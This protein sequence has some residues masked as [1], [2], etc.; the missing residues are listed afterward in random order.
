MKRPHHGGIF[1]MTGEG[2]F[3]SPVLAEAFWARRAHE[4]RVHDPQH[5]VAPESGIGLEAIFTA[6]AARWESRRR[7]LRVDSQISR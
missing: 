7:P 4:R 2:I 1:I 5:T 3:I 6:N